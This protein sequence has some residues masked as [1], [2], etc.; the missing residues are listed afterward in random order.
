MSRFFMI[1]IILFGTSTLF[2]EQES[3]P[4][5]GVTVSTETVDLVPITTTTSNE[6]QTLA[7]QSKA[8]YGLQYGMQTQDFRTTF[9]LAGNSNYQS[10]DV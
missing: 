10:M 8:S 7:S 3:F 9:T 6:L 5:I 4:F 1:F 2:A